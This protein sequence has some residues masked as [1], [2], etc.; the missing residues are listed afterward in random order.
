MKKILSNEMSQKSRGSSV[1]PLQ[2]AIAVAMLVSG[3]AAAAAE[4]VPSPIREDL[5]VRSSAIHWPKGYVPEIAE[6][7]AHNEIMVNA[8]CKRVWQHLVEA[9]VWPNWYSNSKDVRIVDSVDGKLKKASKFNWNTFGLEI[10]SV[11]HEFVPDSRLGWF[12]K[13]PD[14]QAYHTW[15]L[16]SVGQQCKVI[17]E[18]VT[19]GPAA[20]VWRKNDPGALHNGHDAWLER[21]K[22]VAEK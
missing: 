10:E 12:G 8:S 18:E 11:I 14:M 15:L 3:A 2:A 16:T 17:T 21:L 1:Q 22:E 6:L 4:P 7:F 20:A 9:Q 13:G 5:A 19:K